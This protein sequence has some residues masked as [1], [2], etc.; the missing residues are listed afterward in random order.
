VPGQYSFYLS[1]TD[2]QG[3]ESKDT[4]NITVLPRDTIVFVDPWLEI[5][6]RRSAR[7][8]R[9]ALSEAT[10]RG[11]RYVVMESIIDKISDLSGIE[12]CPNLINVDMGLQDITDLAPIGFLTK[13]EILHIDQNHNLHEI[14]PL[15]GLT[16]L[17][18]LNIIDTHVDDLSPLA[19][20]TRLKVLKAGLVPAKDVTFLAQL[21]ELQELHL[22]EIPF[23]TLSILQGKGELQVLILP[24]CQIMDISALRNCT[25]LT[26]LDLSDAGISDIS[27]LRGC[28]LLS[29]L[30]LSNNSIVDVSAIESMTQL[31]RLSLAGNLVYDISP[32]V[33]NAGL[34]VGDAIVL[35]GNPLSDS[36]KNVYVPHLRKRG[37]SVV[38]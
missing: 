1:V 14:S 23:G 31:W 29:T 34:G 33:R 5:T 3:Y 32:L 11:I 2:N 17:R 13:L 9:G 35:W 8:P 28:T 15:S 25:K 12:R 36:S 22:T 24:Y 37:A 18:E 27:P 16:S 6:I 7:Q 38:F 10:L 26:Y 21:N 19:S 20:L 30:T 4:L